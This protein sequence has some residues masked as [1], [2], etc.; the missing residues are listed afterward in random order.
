MRE[1]RPIPLDYIHM[2]WCKLDMLGTLNQTEQQFDCTNDLQMFMKL[3]NEYNPI[4]KSQMLKKFRE[5]VALDNLHLMEPEMK[6]TAR[7]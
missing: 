5:I 4:R 7:G 3:F 2:H 6:T 1:G